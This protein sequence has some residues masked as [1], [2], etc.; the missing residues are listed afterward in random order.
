MLKKNN[1]EAKKKIILFGIL[2]LIL[3]FLASYFLQLAYSKYEVNAKINANISKALYILD[4]EKL[5]FN[6]EPDGII[7]SNEPYTYRFSIS[8][9][10]DNKESDVDIS[11]QLK[12]LTTTNLPLNIKMYR[13]EYNEDATN[14][15]TTT[16]TIQDEYNT[17][18]KEYKIDNNFIMKDKQT[19][20]H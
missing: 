18:Y 8:N 13:N 20:I 12:I 10:K 7:P 14:L 11:Y 6:I 15:I 2:L 19:F 16:N 4:D 5:S 3:L 1:L 9:Y 17:W